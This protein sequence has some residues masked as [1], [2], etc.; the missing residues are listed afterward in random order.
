MG[1]KTLSHP[2]WHAMASKMYDRHALDEE[3]STKFR[4]ALNVEGFRA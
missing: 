2:G 3:G 1:P 4:T